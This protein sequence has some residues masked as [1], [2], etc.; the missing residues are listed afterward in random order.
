MFS[1]LY[2]IHVFFSSL[3]PNDFEPMFQCPPALW[4]AKYVSPASRARYFW[5]NIPGMYRYIR[6][7]Y[8]T[9]AKWASHKEHSHEFQNKNFLQL[10]M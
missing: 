7:L 9:K 4:D 10:A 8:A 3:E 2:T 6:Q 1:S 5:G